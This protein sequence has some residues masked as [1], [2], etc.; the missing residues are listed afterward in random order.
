M[1]GLEDV[2]T[3]G[4][5]EVP[6]CRLFTDSVG[7][8]SRSECSTP[9]QVG[10][11]PQ[12]HLH[13]GGL[14]RYAAFFSP[15]TNLASPSCASWRP[16]LREVFEMKKPPFVNFNGIK[17]TPRFFDAVSLEPDVTIGF[18]PSVPYLPSYPWLFDAEGPVAPLHDC[19]WSFFHAIDRPK[20]DGEI[21]HHQDGDPLNATVENLGV[22][23]RSVHALAHAMKRQR[24][25]PRKRWRLFGFYRPRAEEPVRSLQPE[26]ERTYRDQLLARERARAERDELRLA[27]L[28]GIRSARGGAAETGTGTAAQARRVIYPDDAADWVLAQALPRLRA[29]VDHLDSGKKNPASREPAQAQGQAARNRPHPARLHRRRGRP[30]APAGEVQLR[31]HQGRGRH[32]ALGRR[33]HQDDARAAGGSR[34]PELAPPPEAPAALPGRQGETVHGEPHVTAGAFPSHRR[35]P[36]PTILAWQ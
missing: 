8:A 31:R 6:A 13:A 24:F 26:V 11:P 25:T 15:S 34:R 3:F 22:G 7:P 35:R 30:G 32:R 23:S 12:V 16:L 5:F 28:Q 18:D 36:D 27:W 1:P 21:V 9:H 33:H 4:R 17:L 20:K 19:V 29:E 2:L 14:G 10:G